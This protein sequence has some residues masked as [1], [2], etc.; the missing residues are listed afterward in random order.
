MIDQYGLDENLDYEII[1]G[2][3]VLKDGRT[4]RVPLH[5]RDA[6]TFVTDVNRF[7]DV[8]KHGPGAV[9]LEDAELARLRAIRDE[10][11]FMKEISDTAAWRGLDQRRK[12]G[13]SWDPQGRIQQTWEETEEDD[14][15]LVS[16]SLATLDT[17]N[18]S[19][20]HFSLDQARDLRRLAYAESEARDQAAWRSP[21]QTFDA[22]QPGDACTMPDGRAGRLHWRSEYS[23]GPQSLKCVPAAHGPAPTG[24]SLTADLDPLS[25]T[26]NLD[27]AKA[28]R[29]RAYAEVEAQDRERWR[30]K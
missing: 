20:P 25:S 21:P 29:E 30:S 27:A 3:K 14:G 2:Q 28:E 1:N 9:R 17:V 24:D 16:D 7:A 12:R 18:P 5:L 11:Y 19:S 15:D 4:M 23:G 6:K 13:T 26:F 8:W 10:A 22:R